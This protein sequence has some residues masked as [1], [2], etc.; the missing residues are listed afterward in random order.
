[1]DRPLG[2]THPRQP[3][4]VYEVNYGY[5]PGTRAPD[6]EPVDAYVLGPRAPVAR[7]A[8][9]VVAVVLRADDIEDKLVVSD[10]TWAEP[11]IVD[12]IR[13]QERHSDSRVV[14]TSTQLGRAADH[15]AFPPQASVGV[16]NEPR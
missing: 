3:D 16:L 8:G 7:F 9:H 5:V 12:R 6:G 2:S 14:T 11:D 10:R 4:L 15:A 13:F 1:M